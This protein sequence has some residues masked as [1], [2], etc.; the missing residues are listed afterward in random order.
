MQPKL[1]VKPLVAM[2]L[3]KKPKMA[4]IACE[5]QSLDPE[6][7]AHSVTPVSHFRRPTYRL[8]HVL[9]QASTHSSNSFVLHVQF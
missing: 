4:L 5:R 9:S 8:A 6:P 7:L 1:A 2:M 3:V